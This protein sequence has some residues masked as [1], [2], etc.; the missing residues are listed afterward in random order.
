MFDNGLTDTLTG[1]KRWSVERQ[2]DSKGE[3][4]VRFHDENDKM[5]TVEVLMLATGILYVK[6]MIGWTLQG[7]YFIFKFEFTIDYQCDM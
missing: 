2:E 4:H 7:R 3:K 6:T 5:P 1:G